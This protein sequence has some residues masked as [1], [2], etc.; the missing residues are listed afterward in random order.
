[1][2]T[3]LRAGRR[4]VWLVVLADVV[5]LLVFVL[6]GIRSHHA[7]TAVGFLRNAGPLL[8]AWFVVAWFTRGYR[9]PGLGSLLRT[10]IIAVPIGL[11][12][13][14]ALVGSPSGGRLLVFLAVGVGVTL[15]FLLLGR[16]IARLIARAQ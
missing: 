9:R 6:I 10:W 2:R 11:L 3:L 14:T 4:P 8:G 13:R 12:V 5:A 1:M 7:A 16:I 15:V